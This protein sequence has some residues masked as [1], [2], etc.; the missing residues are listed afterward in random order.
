MAQ[1]DEDDG[2]AKFVEPNT[3]ISFGSWSQDSIPD[4]ENIGQGFY[5]FGLALPPDALK[6]DAD[7]YIGYLVRK[8]LPAPLFLLQFGSDRLGPNAR[9]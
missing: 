5:Q 4:P 8:P 1:A 2:V 7:E 9:L 6:K 3:N